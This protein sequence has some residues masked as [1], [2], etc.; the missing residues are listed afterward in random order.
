MKMNSWCRST[1]EFSDVTTNTFWA[2]F[3]LKVSM[4]C[5]DYINRNFLLLFYFYDLCRISK[6][7]TK[8]E[9]LRTSEMSNI[10]R[11]PKGPDGT[12]GFSARR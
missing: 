4:F 12:R 11:L 3:I 5:I 8:M 1:F 9:V 7:Q 6:I 10:V 2:A